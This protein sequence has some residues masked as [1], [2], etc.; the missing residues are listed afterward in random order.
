M[1][2]DSVFPYAFPIIFISFWI[3]LTSMFRI[4]CGFTWK[5]SREYANSRVVDQALF[6]SGQIRGVSF[7]TC[8]HVI[9]MDNGFLL[10]IS[11]IFSGGSR[12]VADSEIR[13]AEKGKILFWFAKLTIF[14]TVEKSIP[15]EKL[16]FYG[17]AVDF[18]IKYLKIPVNGGPVQ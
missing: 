4:I 8:L 13:K 12:Y 2:V 3:F 1:S 7:R 10:K 16:V 5:A 14:I 6:S 9:R 17:D 15:E 18:I 11:R